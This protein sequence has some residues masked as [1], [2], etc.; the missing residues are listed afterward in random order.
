MEKW[1]SN[2]LGEWTAGQW[3]IGL[4]WGAALFAIAAGLAILVAHGST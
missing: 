2:L 1:K 4:A 3:L